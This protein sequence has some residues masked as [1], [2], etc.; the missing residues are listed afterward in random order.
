M[1]TKDSSQIYSFLSSKCQLPQVEI[2]P[3]TGDA[4]SRK[5]FRV[6][7]PSNYKYVLMA[8][9]PFQAEKYPF[10]SV[11]QHFKKHKVRV[12]E[13]IGFDESLGLVLLEDLGDLTLEQI[14][15]EAKNLTDFKPYYDQAIAELIKIHFES[16]KDHSPCTAFDLDF[17]IEKL[18]WELNFTKSNL[19]EK[20]LGYQ[21]TGTETKLYT[22]SVLQ[23]TKV[24]HDQPKY[25]QHRDYHSRN[26]MIKDGKIRVIDFQDARMG[27]IQYDLVSLFKDSYV[28][29]PADQENSY[30]KLYFE[31][32]R[33]RGYPTTSYDE[34]LIIYNLQAVQR[35]LK[36][37]GSFASFYVLKNDPRY[38]K[39][40]QSTL[41]KVQTT[42][43]HFGE[44]SD[45]ANLISQTGAYNYRYNL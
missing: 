33:R 13:V 38:L 8:W 30:L 4:S 34:F 17:D 12:P 16:T 40:L 45:F 5:Y 23:I 7:T 20:L 44:L 35:C 10:F 37:C 27:A 18:S 6:I 22:D 36:A 31:E 19:F 11:L 14:F 39:Y 25:I 29:F 21:F 42:L 1:W 26:L 28:D 43:G 32:A 2:L 15:S 3:L 41:S 24:L 9:E